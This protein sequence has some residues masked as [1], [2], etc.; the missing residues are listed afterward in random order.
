M[1]VTPFYSSVREGL[2]VP[3]SS[4]YG[5]LRNGDGS[6]RIPEAS[7]RDPWVTLA[8]L[9]EAASPSFPRRFA[10]LDLA[11]RDAPAGR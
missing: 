1:I 3:F 2:Y 4:G 5:G 6:G 8:V 9:E 11:L 10:G 7:L